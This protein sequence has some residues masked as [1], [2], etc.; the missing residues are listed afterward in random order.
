MLARIGR[1]ISVQAQRLNA[2][3]A[4][5]DPE[6]Q[7]IIDLEKD[8][9]K[10][11]IVLIA[12]ENFT[13]KS[14]LEALGSIMTNK[15]SE[16]YP[17]ARYYG[18]NEFIDMAENLCRDR[19]LQAYR[20]NPEAWGVNV[21]PLSGSPANFYVYTAVLGP[22]GRLMALD[23]PHGGH[24]SHGFQSDTRKVSATSMYFES[25][26]Y[27]VN[28]TTGIIDYDKLEETAKVYRPKLLIGGYSAYP[29][30]YDYE[31][32]RAIADSIGAYFMYD[33]AHTSGI[34][35]GDVGLKD[36]F[37]WADIV[38]TTT[39]KSLR[40]PRGAMIFYRQGARPDGKGDYDLKTR[41]EQA[42]FPGH[43]GGPH[44][45]TIAA[46]AV[47]LKQATTPEFK[48]YQRQVLKNAQALSQGLISRGLQVVTG[49]TDNHLVILDLRAQKIDGARVEK[50]LEKASIATNKNTIPGDKSAFVPYGIRLGT[51]AMTSRGFTEGDFDKVADYIA[52]GIRAAQTIKNATQG[53][54]LADFLQTLESQ[55]WPDLESL[56]SEVEAFST[57]FPT[58]GV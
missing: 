4:E 42:V 40:G 52:K 51:P 38:T 12:S 41:I 20:L 47:A 44:N 46:L 13:S 18:G 35:A 1:S 8:R 50:V 16:G 23:L 17:G 39:H 22:H 33:M 11:S 28:E 14:V 5:V 45:H 48:E 6:V 53:K 2:S 26:P 43:Q 54:K 27:R 7:R 34:V 25:L 9:Q 49:G 24:L 19:A 36:P 10:K 58:I 31:R 32:M 30:D 29:R 15:Y 37:K 56:K 21:Q 55:Q 3:L 57:Q